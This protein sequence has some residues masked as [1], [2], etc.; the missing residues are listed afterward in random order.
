VSAEVF[1]HCT[2]IFNNKF[3]SFFNEGYLGIGSRSGFT[4]SLPITSSGPNNFETVAFA[5]LG[6]IVSRT[7]IVPLRTKI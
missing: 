2:R 1:R 3:L 6:D 4:K 7:P 5:L